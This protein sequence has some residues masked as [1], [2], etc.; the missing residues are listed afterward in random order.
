MPEEKINIVV[1]GE[2]GE[3]NPNVTIT[4]AINHTVLTDLTSATFETDDP[5]SFVKFVKDELGKR[6]PADSIPIHLFGSV[7]SELIYTCSLWEKPAHY[8]QKALSVIT[9]KPSEYATKFINRI[10]RP[11]SLPELNVVCKTFLK[12]DSE[13]ASLSAIVNFSQNCKFTQVIDYEQTF[14]NKGNC[15]LML[16]KTL[17][18][19]GYNIEIP[20]TLT[21]TFPLFES[22]SLR[23]KKVTIPVQVIITHNDDNGK[24]QIFVT[25][26]CTGATDDL[27][28]VIDSFMKK[29]YLSEF[30]DFLFSG[31]RI[32]NQKKNDD[33]IVYD[34]VKV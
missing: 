31:K 16:N 1:R 33:F 27:M 12:H 29:E 24:K 7:S 11:L 17:G 8:T 25:F 4:R 14:D 34:P 6:E 9:M 10:N 28:V 18:E 3:S 19:K 32:L 13:N 21:F 5:T 15:K 2:G 23:E 30:E 22:P 20:E 26:E